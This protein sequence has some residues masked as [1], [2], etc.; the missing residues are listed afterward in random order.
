MCLC[1]LFVIDCVMVSGLLFL[2][3]VFVRLCFMSVVCL[4]CV[5]VL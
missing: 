3:C 1:A 2:L 5:P 4:C